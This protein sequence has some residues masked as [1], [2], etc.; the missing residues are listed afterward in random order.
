MIAFIVAH[1]R[2]ALAL[3]LA[4]VIYVQHKDNQVISA[5]LDT[6]QANV[7]KDGALITQQNQSILNA[8]QLSDQRAADAAKI[9][10]QAAVDAKKYDATI[11][12]LKTQQ[13][14]KGQD[15]CVAAA[16]LL[17]EAINGQT[18]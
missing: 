1:W 7:V 6:A 18:H 10:A 3:G 12:W 8:K 11:A 15:R 17:R 2:M 5:K 16:G 4:V 9:Q 14:A 13:P